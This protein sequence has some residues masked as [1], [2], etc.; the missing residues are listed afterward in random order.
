MAEMQGN[1]LTR[2]Y[3]RE[4]AIW[5]DGI[6]AT[7]FRGLYTRTPSPTSEVDASAV[8]N[9]IVAEDLKSSGFPPGVPPTGKD[10]GPT[11][12]AYLCLDKEEQ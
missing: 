12:L 9:K 10:N 2:A 8:C 11:V 6:G 3:D 5:G 7:S 1:Y 4:T